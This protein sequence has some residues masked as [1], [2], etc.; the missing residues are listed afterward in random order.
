MI[1]NVELC[2]QFRGTMDSTNNLMKTMRIPGFPC[3]KFAVSAA[4]PHRMPFST[5][6]LAVCEMAMTDVVHDRNKT[7]YRRKSGMI[8]IVLPGGF[9]CDRCTAGRAKTMQR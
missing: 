2:L 6:S 3:Y 4:D 7:L 1:E 5:S 9:E 8:L